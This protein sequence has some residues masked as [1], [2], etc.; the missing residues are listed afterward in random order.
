MARP[1]LSRQ[2]IWMIDQDLR[3][4]LK[5]DD[6]AT[7]NG[8]ARATVQKIAKQAAADEAEDIDPDLG[9]PPMDA[10]EVQ[11]RCIHIR[12]SILRFASTEALADLRKRCRVG[13]DVRG[14]AM[15]IGTLVA[16]A[17][18]LHKAVKAEKLATLAITS[19]ADRERAR[20]LLLHEAAANGDVRAVIELAKAWRLDEEQLREIVVTINEVGGEYRPGLT[21]GTTGDHSIS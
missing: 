13:G 12:D 6:I 10:E 2:Q 15:A 14:A 18:E 21:A 11:R 17:L 3:N 5:I 7:R 4:G 16:K 9:A 20:T 1:S 19:T 8:V